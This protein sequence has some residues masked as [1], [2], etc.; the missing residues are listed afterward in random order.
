M[1]GSVRFTREQQRDATGRSTSSAQ[2]SA[3][4]VDLHWGGQAGSFNHR[5]IQP[6]LEAV[7]GSERARAMTSVQVQ[8]PHVCVPPSLACTLATYAAPFCARHASTARCMQACC[9]H[10]DVQSACGMRTQPPASGVSVQMSK[11]LP[12]G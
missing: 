7:F 5:E 8:L 10:G 4:G 3:S 2:A 9:C 11:L 12:A 1:I 6:A